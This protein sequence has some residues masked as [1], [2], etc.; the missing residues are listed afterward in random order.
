MTPAPWWLLT[1]FRRW[2]SIV[3]AAGVAL[4]AVP[5]TATL[6][7]LARRRQ[8]RQ[9]TLRTVRM[10]GRGAWTWKVLRIVGFGVAVGMFVVLFA[11]WL[12][13][14]PGPLPPPTSAGW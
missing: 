14:V 3:T 7:T 2:A 8:L 11:T 4:L 12:G 9:F 6:A 5:G 1:T 13:G 10:S